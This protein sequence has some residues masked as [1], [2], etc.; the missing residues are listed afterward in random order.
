MNITPAFR[1]PGGNHLNRLKTHNLTKLARALRFNR[2]QLAQFRGQLFRLQSRENEKMK[3][4]DTPLGSPNLW[5]SAMDHARELSQSTGEAAIV[6]HRPQDDKWFVLPSDTP[7]PE[8][9]T[10]KTV[11][12]PT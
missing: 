2:N 3:T 5:A 1:P 11:I 7:E 6:Y 10:I 9:Q 8:G 4:P 12:L